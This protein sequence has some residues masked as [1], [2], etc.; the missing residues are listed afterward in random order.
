MKEADF[1]CD[2]CMRKV[3]SSCV[4]TVQAYGLDTDACCECRN[5]DTCDCRFE[6]EICTN[7]STQ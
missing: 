7:G 4:E 6:E 5:D 3:P 2:C 1:D